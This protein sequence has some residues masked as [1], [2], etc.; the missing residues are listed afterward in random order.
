MVRALKDKVPA[1][2]YLIRASVLDR[3]VDNKLFYKFI[4]YG[5]KKKEK[6]EID[7]ENKEEEERKAKIRAEKEAEEK[8]KQ[9]FK[10]VSEKTLAESQKLL[11]PFE[12]NGAFHDDSDEEDKKEEEESKQVGFNQR[13]SG[14]K[15]DESIN[16][17]SSE[18]C[19]R[20]QTGGD[21]FALFA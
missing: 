1:G 11:N 14:V 17:E 18:G 2:N 9:I 12:K 4:E 3:L 5:N 6:D 8:K 20:P 21:K 16:D 13:K 7:R 19:P 10:D 15:F